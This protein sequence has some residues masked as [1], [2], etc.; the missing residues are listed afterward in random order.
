MF[1]NTDFFL[2]E[3]MTDFDLYILKDHV[4]SIN[5]WNSEV[6]RFYLGPLQQVLLF[7]QGIVQSF[8]WSETNPAESSVETSFF[9]LI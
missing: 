9:I 7:L 4:N 3:Y 2:H 6:M 5:Y 1:Y 8:L